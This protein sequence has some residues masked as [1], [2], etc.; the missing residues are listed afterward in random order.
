MIFTTVTVKVT[1]CFQ[2]QL[3]LGVWMSPSLAGIEGH[4][5]LRTSQL[6]VYGRHTLWSLFSVLFISLGGLV[7]QQIWPAVC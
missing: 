4:A 5:Q 7:Q 1:G 6:S 3:H 2:L